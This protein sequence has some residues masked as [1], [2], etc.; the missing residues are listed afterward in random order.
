MRR[1]TSRWTVL[2]AVGTAGL[3]CV[4]G[5]KS[6]GHEEER[7]KAYVLDAVPADLP[8]KADI[9]YENKVHL[10]G[11]KVEPAGKAGPGTEVK[12]TMYW[13]ADDKLEEGWSLFTHVL[14]SNN[15][16]ILNIDNVG[17]LRE[18]KESHQVLWPSAWKKGKVYV[19]EQS[20]RIPDDVKTPEVA[21]TTGIWKGDARLKVV[22]GP[23][24]GE[25]R[26]V[27]VRI[28]T[29]VEKPAAPAHTE[30]PK[31]MVNRL[32]KNDKINVD[33]KLDDEA[34]KKAAN[35]GP[36]VDV[37]TGKPN[38]SFP[39]N[40]SAKITW[41]DTNLYVGMEVSDPDIIGGFPK[42]AKDP[43]LWEKD[44]VEIM[45]DPD[46]DGDNTDYY[47]IQVNPQNLVFD[48]QY[49]G[50]NTPKTE[51]AGPFGHQD[52]SAKLK[53][54]VVVDGTLDKP[55]DKDKGYTV[56]IAIPWSSFA[57][58]KVHPPKPG[59][60]WRMN[61]YAMKNNSGVAWSPIMGEGNFHKA[62]RF[63]RVTWSDP[64]QAPA[65]PSASASAG[66]VHLVG[67][68]TLPP[69]KAVHLPLHAAPPKT[70]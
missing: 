56:E 49:D 15:D 27:V 68:T 48:T 30:V 2:L 40:G 28:K 41:D 37:G 26:G 66:A 47:E 59:D 34:W 65:A 36:F 53:S 16:R 20:F 9:N 67:S 63:G 44:T 58:A 38:T 51:P 69:G 18:I 24:D 6:S 62:S 64:T 50:Y 52:W 17:P 43:H 12:L 8:N 23:A 4:G 55:G 32:A 70:P 14:D 21:V 29:G 22:G 3:G 39:V 60:M 10:V 13:R 5:S 19:D 1:S 61:F 54:A 46:G 31:L 33:G 35:I 45:V 57:K 42:D 7:L 11:Y 25:N